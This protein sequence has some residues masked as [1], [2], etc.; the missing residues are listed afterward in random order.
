MQ[1]GYWYYS[2][3]YFYRNP[4]LEFREDQSKAFRH[5]L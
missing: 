2:P 3:E 5:F 1:P 4:V